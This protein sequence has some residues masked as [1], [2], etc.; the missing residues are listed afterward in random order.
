MQ[1]ALNRNVN[2]ALMRAYKRS[3]NA[4]DA[5]LANTFVSIPRL[6]RCFVHRNIT[7]FTVEGVPGR[8][9]S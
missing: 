3:E 5:T 6:S 2:R 1:S 8:L 4:D 9:T 7:L